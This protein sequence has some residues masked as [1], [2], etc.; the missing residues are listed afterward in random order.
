MK[1]KEFSIISVNYIGDGLRNAFDREWL[2]LWA[3]KVH[4]VSWIIR[5]ALFV[6][7]PAIETIDKKA[8]STFER[9]GATRKATGSPRQAS[10]IMTEFSVIACDR[11]C[12]SLAV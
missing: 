9:I 8:Q 6:K 10:Q 2:K 7:L 4:H 5:I 3:K 11:I 1:N 12:V